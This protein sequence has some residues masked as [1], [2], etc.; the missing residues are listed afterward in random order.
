MSDP[1]EKQGIGDFCAPAGICVDGIP[2]AVSA[3]RQFEQLELNKWHHL[4][5]EVKGFTTVHFLVECWKSVAMWLAE[6]SESY[7]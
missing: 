5:L 1:F 6:F 4:K 3:Q 2:D 7:I